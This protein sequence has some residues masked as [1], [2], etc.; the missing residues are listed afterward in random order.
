MIG[1]TMKRTLCVLCSLLLAFSFT[2]FVAC[3]GGEDGEDTTA[4]VIT[5][6]GDIPSGIYSGREAVIPAASATDD[7]DGDLSA[8][9]QVNVYYCQDDGTEVDALLYHRSA[10]S[11]NTITT[12]TDY[13]LYSVEYFVSDAA[14]NRGTY[15]FTFTTLK[16][17]IAPVMTITDASF[18][19]DEGIT[20]SAG[21]PVQLPA[22]KATDDPGAVDLTN[23][24]DVTVTSGSTTVS[25]VKYG[26]DLILISGEYTVTYSVSDSAGNAAQS[27]SFPLSVAQADYSKNLLLNQDWVTL[28]TDTNFNEYG[29]LMVGKYEDGDTAETNSYATVNVDKFDDEIIGVLVNIDPPAAQNP[30]YF[31]TIGYYASKNYANSAP[32]GLEGEWPEGFHFRISATGIELMC[33]TDDPWQ[34]VNVDADLFDGEDHWLYMKV[35]KMGTSASDADAAVIFSIWVDTLPTETASGS[36]TITADTVSHNNSLPIPFE[37]FEAYFNGAAGWLHFGSYTV[38]HGINGDDRMEVKCIA[39][40]DADATEF[41]VSTAPTAKLGGT[42][43][44]RYETGESI[45]VPTVIWTGAASG[46][47]RIAL[48]GG[49]EEQAVTAGQS[50][51]LDAAGEYKL[52]YTAKD[53]D[54]NIGYAEISFRV[55]VANKVPPVITVDTTTINATVGTPFEIPIASVTDDIDGDITDALVITIDGVSYQWD[56]HNGNRVTIMAIGEHEIVYSATDSADNTAEVRVTVNVTAPAGTGEGNIISDTNGWTTV[57]AS[58]DGFTLS[59]ANRSASY[60]TVYPLA[61]E[62]DGVTTTEIS[63][64]FEF[65]GDAIGEI[66]MINIGGVSTNT[67]WPNGL[68][69]SSYGGSDARL[70]FGGWNSNTFALASTPIVASTLNLTATMRF[71]I[72]NDGTNLS[73]TVYY[74]G[75]AIQWTAQGSYG[76]SVSS[77]TVTIPISAFAGGVSYAQY[78]GQLQFSVGGNPSGQPTINITEVRIDGSALTTQPEVRETID[79]PTLSEGDPTVIATEGVT[80]TTDANGEIAPQQ[81]V[82]SSGNGDLIAMKISATGAVLQE[83]GDNFAIAIAG[84]TTNSWTA[85][86]LTIKTSEKGV[87]SVSLGDWKCYVGES[88]TALSSFTSSTSMEFWLMYRLTYVAGE[89]AGTLAAVK[90][91]VWVGSDLQNMQKVDFTLPVIGEGTNATTVYGSCIDENGDIYI[92]AS[93]VLENGIAVSNFN[94]GVVTAG[95]V[96][97]PAPGY[98]Y[99]VSNVT[100]NPSYTEA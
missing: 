31:Y 98:S 42:L 70:S 41:N 59:T 50:V 27:V 55:I 74:N 86:A 85:G 48:V 36:F 7:R 79:M 53:G 71:V 29:N 8:S 81:L 17:T 92:P 51:T 37:T 99:T 84:A 11:A 30:E 21:T 52:V 44:S 6:T 58:E 38:A 18:D 93:V 43:E 78:A 1:K 67:D 10:A 23:S 34:Q 19:A 26:S 94:E 90:L 76:A 14:G 56:I 47:E 82:S 95:M 73:I 28:G 54:G 89:D 62:Q 91:E 96:W 88:T 33:N 97:A 100:V 72:V 57:G 35:T 15:E 20:G 3:G 60:V 45:I 63:M 68:V 66:F 87:L 64:A 40:Y 75:E 83:N 16:D 24:I 32:T 22:V 12:R 80:I 46:T 39:I 4:P 9:V 2:A 5:L 13:S 25:R 69:F 65:Q 77:G 49:E 61:D